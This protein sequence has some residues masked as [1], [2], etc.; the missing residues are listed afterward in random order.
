MRDAHAACVHPTFDRSTHVVLVGLEVITMVLL[1]V[2][3]LLA[4]VG[5]AGQIGKS[6]AP[7]FLSGEHLMSTLDDVLVIFVLLELL[8][9]AVAY[10][11]GTDVM[12]RI[13]E[14]VFV[15][16]ARKLI[17]L[18]FTTAPA[19]SSLA[20]AALLVGAGL[21]WWLV[22]RATHVRRPPAAQA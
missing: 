14:T 17:T 13:F 10:L 5:L 4:I 9:T 18:E 16:I 6:L 15:A 1:A 8:R 3:V 7:P 12:R 11:R 2:L 21:S 19:T 20:V 22:A